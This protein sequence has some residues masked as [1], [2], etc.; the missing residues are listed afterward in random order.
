MCICVCV[1]VG[2][3]GGAEGVARGQGIWFAVYKSCKFHITSNICSI[4]GGG[5]M[6]RVGEGWGG[7]TVKHN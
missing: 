3:W 7:G 5:W 2:V 4:Y 6:D 1:W